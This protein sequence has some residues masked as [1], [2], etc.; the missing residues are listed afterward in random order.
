MNRPS[1]PGAAFR[2]AVKKERPLQVIGTVTDMRPPVAHVQAAFASFAKSDLHGKDRRPPL[3]LEVLKEV[4]F[5]FQEWGLE[6]V[7]VRCVADRLSGISV[8]RRFG[9]E[10]LD[11]AGTANHEQPDD[12]LRPRRDPPWR[13]RVIYRQ[14]VAR[15]ETRH[16]DASKARAQIGQELS[17]VGRAVL[18]SVHIHFWFGANPSFWN[19]RS[20]D[21]NDYRTISW[22]HLSIV[23]FGKG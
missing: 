7:G 20:R 15:Q 12:V 19:R 10:R 22:G 11:V 4:P 8:E 2:D 16:R 17:A 5:V 3:S 13:E 14:P 23:S 21:C 6:D 1:S 18:L 9:V